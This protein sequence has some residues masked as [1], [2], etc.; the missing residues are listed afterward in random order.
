MDVS[1][2]IAQVNEQLF[3]RHSGCVR[4]TGTL[5]S[6][7]VTCGIPVD[8]TGR[9]RRKLVAKRPD[10]TNIGPCCGYRLTPLTKGYEMN[11]ITMHGGL[12]VNG[13]TVIV[14]VGRWRGVRHGG[15]HAFQRAQPMAALPVAEIARV[16]VIKARYPLLGAA[17]VT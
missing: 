15:W 9:Y 5:D 13:R 10:A 14:H 4:A 8:M 6:D 3:S 12:T 16:A 1:A 11:H 7:V 2:L 17:P